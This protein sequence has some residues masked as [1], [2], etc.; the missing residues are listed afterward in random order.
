MLGKT[1][2]LLERPDREKI[3]KMGEISNPSVSDI[4]MG[5]M[6]GTS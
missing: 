5:L 6:G 3:E 1:T 2:F 4:F